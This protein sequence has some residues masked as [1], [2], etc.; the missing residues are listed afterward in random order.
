[1]DKKLKCHFEQYTVYI[2]MYVVSS[3]NESDDNIVQETISARGIEIDDTSDQ[4]DDTTSAPVKRPM[5]KVL[6]ACD[7]IREQLECSEKSESAL[8]HRC[9]VFNGSTGCKSKI[10][11]SRKRNIVFRVFFIVGLSGYSWIYEFGMAEAIEKSI[12]MIVDNCPAH[13]LVPGLQSIKLFFYYQTL[14]V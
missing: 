8:M 12:V 7:I 6:A 9:V 10:E 5:E 14:Q 2:Y 4:E 13:P 11:Y 3:K 1:M